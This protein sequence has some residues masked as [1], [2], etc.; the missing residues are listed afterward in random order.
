M[1]A[2]KHSVARRTA[3]RHGWRK[4]GKRRSCFSA[5]PLVWL[6]CA[7]AIGACDFR[8]S[9]PESRATYFV[10]KFIVAPQAVEDLRGVASLGAD[11]SPETLVSDLPTRAAVSYLRARQRLGADLGFHA[12]GVTRTASGS[13]VVK[14]VVS[15]VAAAKE[16]AVR[17]EVE[18]RNQ[19][20]AWLVV[21]LQSD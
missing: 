6:L 12:A 18:L 2:D 5:R 11:A 9:A 20:Q 17:F 13:R 16:A 19:D 15:E 7:T 4:C 3:D 1:N 14:V 21:R 10:E 8:P